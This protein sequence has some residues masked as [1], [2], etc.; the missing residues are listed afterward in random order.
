MIFQRYGH[1]SVKPNNSDAP[2]VYD[3]GTCFKSEPIWKISGCYPVNHAVWGL[4]DLAG[5]VANSPTI[6]KIDTVGEFRHP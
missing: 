2:I 3:I 5:I 1:K 4:L 6:S